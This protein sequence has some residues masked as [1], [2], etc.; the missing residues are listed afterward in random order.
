M[1]EITNSGCMYLGTGDSFCRLCVLKPLRA[2]F[3]L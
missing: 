1:F 3:F 2:Q